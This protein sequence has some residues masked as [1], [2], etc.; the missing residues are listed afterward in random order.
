M[1][2]FSIAA[3]AST[4]ALITAAPALAQNEVQVL[5]DWRY[6]T[7]YTEGWSVEN[8]LDMTEILDASGEDIGDVENVIFSNEGEILGII[9][10]VGGFWDIGDTHIHVPWDA[11]NIVDGIAQIQ[12]PVN[13]ENVDD[14]DVFG[15]YRDEERVTESDTSSV[16]VVDDDLVSGVNVFKATD[17]MG[18]YAYLSDGSRYGYV[19]DIIVN[20]DSISAVVSD[21]SAYGRRGYYAYPYGGQ[22]FTTANSSRYDMEYNET[23][24]DTIE[25]FDYNQLQSRVQ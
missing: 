13:E 16:A 19:S 14:Y 21:A 10:Q 22:S 9:A 3:K 15:T 12:V 8:M 23:E 1:K 5:T 20:D 6:D 2:Q 25:S 18:D 7:L 4:I 24:I 17:L 11:V